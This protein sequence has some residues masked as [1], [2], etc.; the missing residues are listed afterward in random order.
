MKSFPRGAMCALLLAGALHGAA[1]AQEEKEPRRI[2]VGLGAQLVPTYPGS[3]EVHARPLFDLSRARG[4]KPFAFEAPD[5]SFDVSLIKSGGVEIGP[6]LNLQGSRTQKDV[7]A[8]LDKVSTT[9]EAGAFAQ[10]LIGS[11]FRV[12]AEGRKGLG[13]H[14][15]WTGMVGA[16]FISRDKDRYLFSIGPRVTLSDVRYH[17]AYFGVTPAEAALS[18]LPAYRP[19][20][21]VQ[22]I[23]ATASFLTQ[24]GKQWGL[25]SY[26]KYDR[27]I[28]DAGRSPVVRQLGSRDQLSGGLALTYTFVRR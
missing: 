5:E 25:Y 17:R 24:L 7:G 4:D 3:D 26:A 28:G 15:G 27:L 10:A 13:G 14:E 16:D 22:A 18:G 12:R 19:D 8:P 6:A 21:G 11:A 2:R 9:I 23:G 1:A 20:G